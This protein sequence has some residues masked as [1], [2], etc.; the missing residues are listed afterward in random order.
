M[1][2]ELPEPDAADAVF[3]DED[4]VLYDDEVTPEYGILGFTLRELLIVGVWLV[5]FLVSFFPLSGGVSLWGIGIQWILP[6]GVPTV[7]VFLLVLRRF[8]PDGIRRVG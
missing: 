7:A 8:S 5:S 6:I 1:S 2:T 4:G 3:S